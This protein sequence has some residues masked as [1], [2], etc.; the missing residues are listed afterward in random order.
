MIVDSSSDAA[1]AWSVGVLTLGG[2]LI[3]AGLAW[4]AL[5]RRRIVGFVAATYMKI[6]DRYRLRRMRLQE[7]RRLQRYSDGWLV[8]RHHKRFRLRRRWIAISPDG[9]IYG[10]LTFRGSQRVKR[11]YRGRS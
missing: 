7:R 2:S 6:G 9:I 10:A 8:Y 11:R 4:A 3:G 5:G 1:F